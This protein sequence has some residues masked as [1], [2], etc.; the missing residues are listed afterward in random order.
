MLANKGLKVNNGNT[1]PKCEICSKLA[2][3][4]PERHQWHRSDVFIV[5]FE[6]ISHLH[7]KGDNAKDY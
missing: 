6:N 3:R 4:T 7:Q 5:N 2:I 1:R